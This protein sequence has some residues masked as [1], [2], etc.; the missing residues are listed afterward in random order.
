MTLEREET[1]PGTHTAPEATL[2]RGKIKNSSQFKIQFSSNQEWNRPVASYSTMW[3]VISRKMASAQKQNHIQLGMKTEFSHLT[4]K[5]P[6]PA[7]FYSIQRMIN[8]FFVEI[9]NY[10][11]ITFISFFKKISGLFSAVPHIGKQLHRAWR[12]EES[13]ALPSVSRRDS[14]EWIYFRFL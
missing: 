12:L 4:Q 14:M 7:V 6:Q 3:S 9:L 10:K 5:V 2:C 8:A 13:Q 1:L 11:T